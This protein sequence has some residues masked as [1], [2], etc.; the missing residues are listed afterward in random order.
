MK[1]MK[2]HLKRV[3]SDVKL[4]FEELITVLAQ[5]EACMNSRP[6]GPLP[7][8]DDALEPL[9]PGYFLI[10]KPLESLTDPSTSFRPLSLLRRWHLCQNLAHHFWTR[11]S[12]E[13]L[14]SLNRLTKWQFPSRNIGVGDVV[15]LREDGL[16]P[17]KWQLAQVMEVHIGRDG[18]VRVATVKTPNGTYKRPVTKLVL[19]L[20]N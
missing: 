17:L 16:I 20:P 3:I 6:L 13:Y 2:R 1:G 4:T 7:S 14:V 5:V 12:K 19:L 11:W 15:V 8:Q 18:I 9:T 10:G